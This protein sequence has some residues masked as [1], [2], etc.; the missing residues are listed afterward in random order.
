MAAKIQFSP[1]AF[2]G[3]ALTPV[4]AVD[5]YD[6]GTLLALL[7]A[8]FAYMDGRIDP[9]SSLHQMDEKSLAEVSKH[10][11]IWVIHSGR[12]PIA[13]MTL[14]PQSDH[15]YLGKMAISPDHQ[16]QGLARQL[17]E[18]A[19]Y[20]ARALGFDQIQLQTR[21]ALVE[22]HVAFARMGFLKIGEGRHAGYDRATDITM[23]KNV[24]KGTT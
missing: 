8:S 16:G 14:S 19:E 5:P 3:A 15:L 23:A 7:R 12:K 24:V 1:G 10:S 2:G 4:R 21:V 9:P 11:E 20:R 22:N 17:V 13:T 18:H 6:W